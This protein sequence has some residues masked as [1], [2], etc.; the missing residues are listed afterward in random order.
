MKKIIAL[1]GLNGSGK[2][3]VANMLKTVI[4]E[5]GRTAAVISL[6]TP[7]KAIAANN[8]GY[9]ESKKREGHRE[10]LERLA[11]DIRYYLG[12]EVFVYALMDKIVQMSEDYI[13]ID[14]MRWFIEADII[15]AF[16][17]LHIIKVNTSNEPTESDYRRLDELIK[18]LIESSFEINIIPDPTTNNV[19]EILQDIF[20]PEIAR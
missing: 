9:D 7:L 10:I 2:S 4:E 14:D 15:S 13:I 16:N 8:C 20:F 19:K 18:E 6:A 5:T 17:E 12:N 3:T 11:A 1:I